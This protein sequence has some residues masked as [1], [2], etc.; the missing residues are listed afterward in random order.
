V[1]RIAVVMMIPVVMACM[2]AIVPTMVVV[3]V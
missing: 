2:A 3:I 1:L